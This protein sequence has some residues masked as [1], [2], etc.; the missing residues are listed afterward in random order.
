VLVLLYFTNTFFSLLGKKVYTITKTSWL[1][2]TY[3][4]LFHSGKYIDY[5][6]LVS[7]STYYLVFNE[8]AL[9][10]LPTANA[11]EI[12]ALW[13]RPDDEDQMTK[14]RLLKSDDQDQMIKIRWLRSD[15]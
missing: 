10:T 6:G 7:T 14:I 8:L 11:E 3:F 5:R 1:N 9:F 15:D 4:D 13:L 2:W 12:Q